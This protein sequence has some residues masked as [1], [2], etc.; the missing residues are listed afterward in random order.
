MSTFRQKKFFALLSQIKYL[1]F[2]SLG[3]YFIYLGDVWDRFR[4]KRTNF[5]QFEEPITELPTLIAHLIPYE[6]SL[7]LGVNFNVSYQAVQSE[8]FIPEASSS[9]IQ[10]GQ[11]PVD[12]SPLRVRFE[13]L[14]GLNVFKISPVNYMPGTPLDY[15]LT[16]TFEEKDVTGATIAL[17]PENNSVTGSLLIDNYKRYDGKYQVYEGKVGSTTIITYSPEKEKFM[18]GLNVCRNTPFNELFFRQVSK[19][20]ERCEKPCTSKNQGFGQSLDKILGHLP[21]C[22]N[23]AERDC[24]E[25]IAQ[26]AHEQIVKKPCTQ[27]QYQATTQTLKNEDQPNKARFFLRFLTPPKATVKEEYLIYDLVAMIGAIGGTMGLCI[28]FSFND[29]CSTVLDY[30]EAALMKVETKSKRLEI[31]GNQ[32]SVT[33]KG[34]NDVNESFNRLTLDISVVQKKQTEMEAKLERLGRMTKSLHQ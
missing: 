33:K 20:I 11:Y 17:A 15:A 32:G 2:L 21:Y 27:V 9:L 3:L 25:N 29:F 4:L 31:I 5:A 14:Y 23:E 16:F 22:K 8:L 10:S 6:N 18:E 7:T 34:F 19:D 30:L 26:N 28:G 1:G 24:F 12:D 13:S